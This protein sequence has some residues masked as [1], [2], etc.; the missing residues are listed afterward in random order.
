MLIDIA[1]LAIPSVIALFI[2]HILVV[3]L[4]RLSVLCREVPFEMG[5]D[6]G[7]VSRSAED[8]LPTYFAP[9]SSLSL[10]RLP[11]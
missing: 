3:K 7:G 6:D 10:V 5:E 11:G 1:F 8:W 2:T 9:N 4:L